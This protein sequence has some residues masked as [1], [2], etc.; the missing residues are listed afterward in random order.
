MAKNRDWVNV[1]PVP[2][3]PVVKMANKHMCSSSLLLLQPYTL[4]VIY[5]QDYYIDSDCEA[6][7]CGSRCSFRLGPCSRD[8]VRPVSSLWHPTLRP[9]PPVSITKHTQWLVVRDR[10][11]N[12]QL[13]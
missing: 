9:T 10:S 11:V 2:D 3:I 12:Y 8:S 5:K 13:Y 6:L 7:T 1:L 4:H